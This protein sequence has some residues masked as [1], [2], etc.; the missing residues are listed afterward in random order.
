MNKTIIALA[1]AGSALLS[2]C[3]TTPSKPLTFDQL[4][5]YTTMPL[6]AQT[7]RISFKA[8]PNM[9]F[10]TAEEITLVKAAQ[11]TVQNGFQFFR[12]KDDPSNLTHQPPREAIV[13]PSPRP[14]P[15]GYYRRHPYG[16][17]DPFYD[18][19]YR[20][21]VEPAQVGYTIE[22]FKQGQAPQDAF[23]ARL[24]LQSLGQ[25]YGLSPS[26]EMLQPQPATTNN[27]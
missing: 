17:Y 23:D 26:G 8:R 11:T 21:T 25:K 24:I 16:W 27:K 22:C 4:G 18:M 13:Y 1:L 6:N 7:Y 20:V 9:S 15:Y 14:Y 3:A 10:G 19:P 2:G 12:V 5:Q